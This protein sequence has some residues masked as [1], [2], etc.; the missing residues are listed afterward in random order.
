MKGIMVTFDNERATIKDKK[1]REIS[2]ICEKGSHGMFYLL[3]IRTGDKAANL[4][5]N[6][7]GGEW[8][9]VAEE[10]DEKGKTPKTNMDGHTCGAHQIWG[11]KGK[12]LLV[13]TAKFHNI[14][15][16]EIFIS[17]RRLWSRNCK[18]KSSV[19]NNQYKGHK[20]L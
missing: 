9:D 17:M 6:K 15:L 3:G 2:F 10:V 12:A 20:T 16:K 4:A 13:K 14:T 7:E 18:P 19:K 5:T 8:Q 1:S 11:H